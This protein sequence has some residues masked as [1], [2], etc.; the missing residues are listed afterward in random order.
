LC[1]INGLQPAPPFKVLIETIRQFRMPPAP[2]EDE[3]DA[4]IRLKLPPHVSREITRHGRPVYYFRRNKDAR[5]RLPDLADPNFRAVYDAV[6]GSYT[7]AFSKDSPVAKKAAARRGKV[8]TRYGIEKALRS[9]QTRAK[10]RGFAI[11]LTME[12]LAELAEAQDFKCALS[13]FE[14]S[15]DN[16]HGTR[17]NPYAL[18]ID[19]ID[20]KGG[21]VIGNVR[22]VCLVL[23]IAL[24]D[25][26]E[27]VFAPFAEAFV[28]QRKRRKT[29]A[30]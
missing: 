10:G 22:L 19:R 9:A 11:D 3:M 23:N 27:D 6:L 28:K 25:W 26:G 29:N 20:P 15:P 14:F 1:N 17:V 8:V 16:R 2:E 18:T 30:D 12:N 7:G 4:Q 24:M 13:G 5:V 21:Y